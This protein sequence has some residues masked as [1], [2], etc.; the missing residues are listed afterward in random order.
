MTILVFWDDEEEWEVYCSC[1][2]EIDELAFL[3]NYPNGELWECLS[4]GYE[5]LW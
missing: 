2:G 5:F 1:C 4:C 3:A